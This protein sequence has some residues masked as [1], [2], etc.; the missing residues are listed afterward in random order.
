PLS[1]GISRKVSLI[2]LPPKWTI[3]SPLDN[4]HDYSPPEVYYQIAPLPL[5][6]LHLGSI[7]FFCLV[8]W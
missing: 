2:P 5:Y 4:R 8:Q 6:L 7:D 3:S 1:Y